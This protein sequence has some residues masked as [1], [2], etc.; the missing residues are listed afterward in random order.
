MISP[1]VS[2]P[3]VLSGEPVFSGT[4]VPIRALFDY[5]EDGQSISDFM[6][7]FP[8]VSNSLIIDVLELASRKISVA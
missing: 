5:L 6:I 3:D 1:V 7:D 8:S 4:R 2:S